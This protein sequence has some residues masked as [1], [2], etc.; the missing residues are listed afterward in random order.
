M[1]SKIISWII[2]VVL[3]ILIIPLCLLLGILNFLWN[4]ADKAVR[5]IN[6]FGKS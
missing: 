3:Y 1:K 6:N 2:I 5:F 4:I